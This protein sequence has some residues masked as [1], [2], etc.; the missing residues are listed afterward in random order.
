MTCIIGL[1]ENGIVYMGGDSGA[2]TPYQTRRTALQKVFF[3]GD[4]TILIGWTSSFRMG[5][6]LQYHL[7]LPLQDKN[8][9]TLEY[10]V[11]IVI[12]KI[13]EAFKE[14]GYMGADEQRDEGGT[15]LLGYKGGLYRV[16]SDFQVNHFTEHFDACGSGEDFALG[17]M[18]ALS[19]LPA[20]ER[21]Y[22]ALDIAA[23]FAPGVEPP[24]YMEELHT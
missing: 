3:A 23:G 18:A 6:I 5:Q 1:A 13:R 9:S 8:Q 7:E 14:F 4:N 24:F 12:Q 11:K 10:L 20:K 16:D 15:F 19:H 17:A 2:S 22:K 21:I